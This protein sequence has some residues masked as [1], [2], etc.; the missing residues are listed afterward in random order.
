MRQEDL[1]P[2]GIYTGIG[3]SETPTSALPTLNKLGF[4]LAVR[5]L[6]LRSGG[7]AGADSAFEAGARAGLAAVAERTGRP[8]PDQLE[9]FRPEDVQPWCLEE[10][11]NHL[12]PGVRL[13]TM[14]PFVRGLLARDMQQVL[15]RDGKRPS[16]F[17]LYWTQ[18]LDGTDRRAGGT[19]YAVRCA[20]AHGIPTLNVLDT[21][22]SAAYAWAAGY[23]ARG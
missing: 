10:L 11:V 18:T 1:M 8:A 4:F 15:G 22:F 7:A 21:D 13:A 20:Q 17:V 14:R 23:I 5:G 3:A 2:R 19:R 6:V 9:I 16:L 12:D